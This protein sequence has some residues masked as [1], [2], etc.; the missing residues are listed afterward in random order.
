MTVHLIFGIPHLWWLPRICPETQNSNAGG[1]A[2]IQFSFGAAGQGLLPIAGD[3]DGN[4]S[5][6]IGLYD[7]NKGD[8][9][10]HNSNASG[11]ADLQLG[12][13]NRG[14]NL[15]GDKPVAGHW[16]LNYC[17]LIG[18][19]SNISCRLPTPIPTQTTIPTPTS[20]APCNITTTKPNGVTLSG[21]ALRDAPTRYAP[22]LDTIPWN[23][24]LIAIYRLDIDSEIWYQVTYA[25]S[26]KTNTAWIAATIDG[27]TFNVSNGN[28]LLPLP[29]PADW[30]SIAQVDTSKIPNCDIRAYLMNEP[31]ELVLARA[32]FGE[33]A[34]YVTNTGVGSDYIGGVVYND[35]IRISWIIRLNA[36]MGLPNYAAPSSKAGV[37]VPIQTQVTR[38]TYLQ[39]LDALDQDLRSNGCDASIITADNI[40]R[41]V[42]PQNRTDDKGAELYELFRIYEN[43]VTQV[44]SAPWQS[45]PKDIAHQDQFKGVPIAMPCPSGGNGLSRPGSSYTWAANQPYPPVTV[46][47]YVPTNDHTSTP[48]STYQARKSCYQDEYHLDDLYLAALTQAQPDLPLQPTGASSNLFP[49]PFCVKV[50]VNPT[51]PTD[52]YPLAQLTGKDGSPW[53][54]GN[55]P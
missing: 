14:Y 20:A 40:R 39:S 16:L 46:F 32:A 55:C 23:T 19:N 51:N 4:G 52:T 8:F 5:D 24:P 41:I 47:P 29:Y 34:E 3:W 35:A 1:P 37:S 38:P 53:P 13:T 2:D 42:L 22:R 44:N 45:L 43:I 28:C 25:T 11:P 31:Q 48:V 15:T 21:L 30:P 33:T 17:P 26:T 12:I 27:V 10:L 50:L 9:Y 54:P 36:F 6:T 49:K 7:P 18:S